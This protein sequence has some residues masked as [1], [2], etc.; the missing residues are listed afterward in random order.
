[1]EYRIIN[2]E[3][4]IASCCIGDLTVDQAAEFLSLW[5]KGTKI[6]SLT[7]FYDSDSQNVVLNED[8]RNFAEMKT[9]TESYLAADS[10]TKISFR[11]NLNSESVKEAVDVL[12]N[13]IKQRELS[14]IIFL[15]DNNEMPDEYSMEY[16][17]PD[18][19]LRRYEGCTF[20]VCAQKI[21]IYGFIQGKR[22]ERAR[23][24]EK[25]NGKN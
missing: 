14:R 23:R 5:R 4:G 11:N 17:L 19:I 7:L 2:S 24:K 21:F 9:L 16:W 3:L 8:H 22:Q 13:A 1:M 12:D 10:E 6:S 25:H 15:L 20:S 18:S